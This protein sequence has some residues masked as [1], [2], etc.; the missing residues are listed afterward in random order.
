MTY[1]FYNSEKDIAI[2]IYRHIPEYSLVYED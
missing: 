2:E 1:I